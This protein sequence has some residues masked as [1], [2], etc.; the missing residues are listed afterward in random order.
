MSPSY[1][2]INVTGACSA[3][4]MKLF[5]YFLAFVPFSQAM[6]RVPF[7]LQTIF[8]PQDLL[9]PS[10]IPQFIL[11]TDHKWL[12]ANKKWLS[13]YPNV[14]SAI[15]SKE[16]TL[17]TNPE[18]PEHA[19]PA[20]LLAR[21]HIENN[22]GSSCFGWKNAVERLKEI[23]DCPAALQHVRTLHIYIYVH[24]TEYS[25]FKENSLPPKELPQLLA[26]ALS[27]MPNL[28]TLH[29]GIPPKSTHLFE[30]AFTKA[31]IM[32]PS[33]KRIIPAA[34]SE[35]IVRR[36]PNLEFLRAGSH[37]DQAFWN[38]YSLQLE[39]YD[40]FDVTRDARI[41]LIKAAKGL[42]LQTITF[43]A[44]NWM[45]TLEA[46]L[47]ATPYITTLNM[48]GEIRRGDLFDPDPDAL[49]QHLA[50]LAQ[51]PNLTHLALPTARYLGLSF[52]GGPSCGNAYF[53]ADGR[54]YG[55][56][57]TQQGAEAVEEAGK[58]AIEMLPHLK[59]LSIGGLRANITKNE[60]GT[61][62]L[63]WPWTGRMT[64]YTYEVWPE[65]RDFTDEYLD[66]L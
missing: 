2:C 25:T 1:N 57:V 63:T 23:I 44:T 42:P 54:A 46:M 5:V 32:L 62:V 61:L 58:M 65:V 16:S 48:D 37:S 50:V 55:R 51:F 64:E 13:G 49:K 7:F 29:W 3:T 11:D 17:W 4:I 36:C 28:T 14:R 39:Y 30:A 18:T 12:N 56:Q 34:Y 31:D 10:K 40:Y 59:T 60:D 20:D 35:W 6:V 47:Q 43:L 9:W 21:I 19:L 38:S 8:T 45:D 53:G 41:D 52:D 27:Q 33:V 22:S 24:D 15:R 66:G 26:E